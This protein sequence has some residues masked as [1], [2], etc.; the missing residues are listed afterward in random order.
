M[1][2]QYSGKRRRVRGEPQAVSK[3]KKRRKRKRR[4]QMR[5]RKR[6]SGAGGVVIFAFL[7][8]NTAEVILNKLQVSDTLCLKQTSE[9]I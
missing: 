1:Y 4:K 3:R 8:S 7:D 6:A 9:R 2:V 5:G